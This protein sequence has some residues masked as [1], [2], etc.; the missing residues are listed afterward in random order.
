MLCLPE[1]QVKSIT[2]DKNAAELKAGETYTYVGAFQWYTVLEAPVPCEDMPGKVVM[3]V[4]RE[5]LAEP[6]MTRLDADRPVEVG[7]YRVEERDDGS[8][9]IVFRSKQDFQMGE[10]V[11]ESWA[12]IVAEGQ[13]SAR[14]LM[15]NG[16][17]VQKYNPAEGRLRELIGLH[18]LEVWDCAW[19][20]SKLDP[21][22]GAL[23]RIEAMA[24][25]LGIVVDEVKAMS[26][27]GPDLAALR[28]ETDK[29]PG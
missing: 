8:Y 18:M 21:M 2:E 9:A 4:T 13:E 23:M 19:M 12:N 17:A 6:L 22:S 27:E 14:D 28:A 24:D 20:H 16:K 3:K 25:K 11:L 15:E 5:G 1:T 29:G 10:A 7:P 26:H